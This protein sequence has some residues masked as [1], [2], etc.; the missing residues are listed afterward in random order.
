MK[1]KQAVELVRQQKR[2]KDWLTKHQMD[3]THVFVNGG[4]NV[5]K[6]VDLSLERRKDKL[7]LHAIWLLEKLVKAH[8]E[9]LHVVIPLLVAHLDRLN[10]EGCERIA[11]NILLECVKNP[12]YHSLSEKDGE[13]AVE[14]CFG[15]LIDEKKAVAVVA[16]CIEF[17]YHFVG[18]H[19]WIKDE[20]IL[21]I[22]VLMNRPSPA[23][24]AR[25]RQVLS[26]LER[27]TK[28]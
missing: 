24:H 4:I 26:R 12:M 9:E 16:N 13:I 14:I 20:L 1:A 19:D 6:L 25:A 10:C 21:Q 27:I 11:G 23:I 18:K 3:T 17:L 22:P 28:A 7:P 2:F 8:P 5:R 15:W